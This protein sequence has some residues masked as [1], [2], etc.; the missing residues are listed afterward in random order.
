MNRPHRYAAASLGLL[1]TLASLARAAPAVPNR[2]PLLAT[3]LVPLPLGDVR[4]TGWL[5][6]ELQLQRDGLTGH[7]EQVIPQLGPRSGW[8]GGTGKDVDAWEKGPYYVKGLVALAYALDDD[9]LKRKAQKWIDW[10]LNS[11]RPNGSF[12]PAANDDWWPRMV[13][14]YALRQYAE[15][16]GDPRVVPM[17]HRYLG[18]VVAD[19]P[20]R[21]LK[22][23]GKARA[24][25]MIDTAFWV[26]NRTGDPAMLRAADLLHAQAYDWTDIFTGNRFLYF[27]D[28]IMPKHAVNVAQALKMPPVWYQRSRVAADRDAFAAGMVHLL[29]GTTLPLDVPTG[30][31]YLS[32]R[33]AIQGVETCTVVEQMLSDETALA[34]LADPAI[35]D[36]LERTAFNAMPGA[37]TK[38]LKLYQYYT[39]T[40]NVAAVRGGHGFDQDYGDGMMPGPVSG[41]PCC[42]YNLHMGWPML[43]QHA[44]MATADGGLAAVVYAPTTVTAPVE[45]VDV[46]L[47]ET[48]NYPFEPDVHLTIHTAKPLT[49][50]LKLRIPGWCAEATVKVNGTAVL[51][52]AHPE[53][54]SFAAVEVKDGD[55]VDLS[56]PMPITAV[57]G[58]N[59][60]VSLARGP[61][62]FS[63]KM[64]QQPKVVTP[65]PDGF[66]HLEITSPDPW[67]FALAVDPANP[68]ATVQVHTAAMPAGNPFEPDVSPVTLTVPG[69]RVPSWGLAWTGR[70]ADDPPVSPVASDEPEQTVTLVPFGAQTLRVTAFPRLGQPPDPAASYHCDFHDTDAPGWVAYGGGWYVRNGQLHAASNAG[71]GSFGTEGVKSVATGTDFA[72]LVYDADVIPAPAG[73]SGLIFRVTHPATGPNAFDGYYVGLSP[74]DGRVML[75]KGSATD[76]A[77][78]ELAQAKVA[79]RAR[80][81][82]HVRIVA[83]G[84]DI[85]VYVG[86]AD[87]PT[88]TATD[89][90]YA[91]GSIGVRQYATD[92]RASVAA[93]ASIAVVRPGA[94]PLPPR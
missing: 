33:S 48:T 70:W 17:L 71:G 91:H 86:N 77:W 47:T 72:D 54:G 41:F 44:W 30:T 58:V 52:A 22:E 34:V 59:G 2:A 82:T 23:W 3:P 36:E 45:G 5:L 75:G 68:T 94:G 87:Q 50:P 7:A 84:P 28:D 46:T 8:L 74:A 25:D 39:A 12:G 88:L 92:P 66:V 55:A 81:V 63:L 11:Q 64:P 42:C 93:F 65:G 31:E 79:V 32:G 56:F 21:P 20:H 29:R 9:G 35:A 80:V 15:A 1:L 19:L 18:Y 67:N 40:N 49:F 26:Y 38:D 90:S 43:V 13:M 53:P 51:Q 10:S 76:N 57:A 62:V 73:D 4:A 16:T 85:R 60:S 83:V 14:T 27:G 37:M 89:A 78:T 6:T 69:R 24:G 61:L